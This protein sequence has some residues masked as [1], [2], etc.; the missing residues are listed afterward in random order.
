MSDIPL[1]GT[2]DSCQD[3]DMPLTKWAGRYYCPFCLVEKKE[4][5][6][7]KVKAIEKPVSDFNKLV[8]KTV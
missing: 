5:T 2:C 3:T 6:K 1:L 8:R 4:G 7:A